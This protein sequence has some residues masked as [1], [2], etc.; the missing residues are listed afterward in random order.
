MHIRCGN[1]KCVGSDM[2][3]VFYTVHLQSHEHIL[4]SVFRPLRVFQHVWYGLY[5]QHQHSDT[6]AHT[7]KFLRLSQSISK[8]TLPQPKACTLLLF[9]QGINGQFLLNEI[10][11]LKWR[12]SHKHQHP[13]QNIRV[14][15]IRTHGRSIRRFSERAIV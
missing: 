10:E 4:L 12:L 9:T 5:L 7:A 6:R 8:I 14:Y 13:M 1:T 11:I 3:I 2:E 15:R